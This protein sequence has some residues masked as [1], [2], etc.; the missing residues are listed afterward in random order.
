MWKGARKVSDY[1]E[2]VVFLWHENRDIVAWFKTVTTQF[3]NNGYG[4][5]S[6]NYMLA[7]REFDDMGLTGD[8]R[9]DWKRKLRILERAY[10]YEMNQGA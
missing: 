7:Y 5:T 4:V 8:I 6:F 3:V 1:P 10:I 2:P 9:E